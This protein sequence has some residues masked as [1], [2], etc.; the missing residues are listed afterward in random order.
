MQENENKEQGYES[1][2]NLGRDYLLEGWLFKRGKYRTNVLK[3]RYFKLKNGHLDSWKSKETSLGKS[4]G[5]EF[6]LPLS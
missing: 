1:D 5:I 2:D 4:H 6:P 3:C